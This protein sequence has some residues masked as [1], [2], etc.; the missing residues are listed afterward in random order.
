M[1]IVGLSN[2]KRLAKRIA[3]KLNLDYED[4]EI[5]DT[6]EGEI[7]VKFKHKL[8]NQKVVLV[9]SLYPHPNYS[10][11]EVLFAASAARDLKAK[12]VIYVAP[13]MAYLKKD[14]RVERGEG[15]GGK[16][17]GDLLS[18]H[19]DS[20]MAVELYFSQHSIKGFFS[21]PFYKLNCSELLREYVLKNLEDVEVIGVGDKAKLLARHIKKDA[22]SYNKGDKLEGFEDKDVVV[23]DN[24]ISSGKTML[25]NLKNLKAN[26]VYLLGV[27]GLFTGD[28]YKNLNEKVEK[29]VTTN[30]VY[31]ETNDLD[32]S[33]LIARKLMEL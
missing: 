21:V 15:I 6:H 27:H 11:F 5:L 31:H 14:S 23:V 4:L 24:T 9:Q 20:V 17:I 22:L 32:V 8:E 26:K 10:L 13:Y 28:A 30:T 7:H 12:E 2:S 1:I 33:G 29:V 3:Q 18:R 25:E 19:V 16:I